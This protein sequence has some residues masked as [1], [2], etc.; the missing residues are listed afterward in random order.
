MIFFGT[1]YVWDKQ[2]N[3]MLCQFKGGQFETEDSHAIKVLQE[4]GYK[5]EYGDEII[6]ESTEIDDELEELK[7]LAKEHG[8]KGYGN[9]KD[10]DKLKEFIA[11]R[12]D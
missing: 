11:E 4:L 10:P 12:V 5:S 6:V 3:K 8:L 1:G 9:I 2:N 7:A